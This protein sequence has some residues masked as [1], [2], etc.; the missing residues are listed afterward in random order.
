MN[1]FAE[2]SIDDDGI[3]DIGDNTEYYKVCRFCG[4]D[5]KINARADKLIHNIV[6]DDG[7]H[8]GFCIR[9]DLHT[10]RGKDTL[11]L[12]MRG[13][14]AH[15]YYNCYWT[16]ENTLF[17]SQIQDMIDAHALCGQIN[18]V[19]LYDPD[20][21]LWFVDF[22]KIGD[23]SKRRISLD[24][25]INTTHDMLS[26]FNLYQYLKDFKGH[27]LVEKFDEALIDFFKKRYRPQ[28]KPHLIPTLIGCTTDT[29]VVQNAPKRDYK[30]FTSRDLRVKR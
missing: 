3:A 28:G 11:V 15:L 17:V 25:V 12:S 19:F 1:T 18:P 14:I 10:R 6:K 2:V 26:C 27:K 7:F 22:R 29:T 13:I 30:T 20:T 16:K 9:H 5:A 21:Y 24:E 4:K 8:C 23:D